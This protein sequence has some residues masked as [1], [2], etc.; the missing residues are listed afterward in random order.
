MAMTMTR[1]K[2][3]FEV[4]SAMFRKFKDE[5]V[6]MKRVNEIYA[7]ASKFEQNIEKKKGSK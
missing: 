4:K 2:N 7:I 6:D 5:S 3:A 1:R